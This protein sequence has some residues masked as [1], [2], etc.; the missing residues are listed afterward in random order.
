MEEML[1]NQQ[2]I[3]FSG[4]GASHQNVSVERAIKMVVTMERITLMHAALIFTEDTLSTNIW[5]W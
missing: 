5:P 4:A 2:Q 3:I 1:K